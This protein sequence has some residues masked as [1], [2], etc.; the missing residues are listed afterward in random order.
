MRGSRQFCQRGSNYDNFLLLLLF[1]VHKGRR[2]ER[3]LYHYN[4]CHHPPTS[5]TPLDLLM[6]VG[7]GQ[8]N[9]NTVLDLLHQACMTLA[10]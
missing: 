2:G 7:Y 8:L 10:I 5:E 6:F 4:A 1:F 3:F 9:S